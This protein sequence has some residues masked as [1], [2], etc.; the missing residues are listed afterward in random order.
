MRDEKKC[1]SLTSIFT[2]RD[3]VLCSALLAVYSE[4]GLVRVES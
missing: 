2:Y 1:Q 3:Q 4:A